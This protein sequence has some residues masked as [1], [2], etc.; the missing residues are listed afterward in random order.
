MRGAT[1]GTLGV[2]LLACAVQC[3]ALQN[4]DDSATDGLFVVPC[5]GTLNATAGARGAALAADVVYDG[6]FLAAR[7]VDA[8][9]GTT[10]RVLYRPDLRATFRTA[11]AASGASTRCWGAEPGFTGLAHYNALV[12]DLRALARCP[13]AASAVEH[14]RRVH[15]VVGCAAAG[16]LAGATVRVAVDADARRPYLRAVAVERG[17]AGGVRL[18]DGVYAQ[19]AL[20]PGHAPRAAYTVAPADCAGVAAYA[21]ART[22]P[23]RAAFDPRCRVRAVS[24][25]LRAA[26]VLAVPGAAA[27]V[28]ILLYTINERKRAAEL[29]KLV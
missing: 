18:G 28:A 23:A 22:P 15:R 12:R 16:Q 14:G 9:H 11:A 13:A 25:L 26:L 21:P 7:V 3:G 2:L 5:A 8:A 24:P 4:G 29:K 27:L 1:V 10:E 20:A 6:L 17:G 19:L